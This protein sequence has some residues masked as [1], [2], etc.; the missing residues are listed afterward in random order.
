M[1]SSGIKSNAQNRAS[2]LEI[3]LRTDRSRL[4]L[5]WAAKL[6]AKLLCFTVMLSSDALSYIQSNTQN[7]AS[8][9]EITLR[10]DRS[11][12][13]LLWAAEIAAKLHCFTV[14]LCSDA[15]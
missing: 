12:L 3:T 5:L 14:T 1:L 6:A 15:L 4:V 11:R 7:R 13:V 10:S 2:E 8:K 9:L